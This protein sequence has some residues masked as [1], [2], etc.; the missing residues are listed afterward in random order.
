MKIAGE[1]YFIKV[2][3]EE[4]NLSGTMFGDDRYW[5][6]L[7]RDSKEHRRRKPKGETLR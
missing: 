1:R 5:T 7:W 6:S 2:S 4:V 3:T